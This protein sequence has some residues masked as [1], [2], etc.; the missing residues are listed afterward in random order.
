ML[1]T[2]PDLLS[3]LR[4]AFLGSY[5]PILSLLGCLDGGLEAKRL[6]DKVIDACKPILPIYCVRTTPQT[7]IGDHVVNLREEI[8]K[9]R[10]KYSVAST[11]NEASRE[12]FLD[13]A[14]KGLEQ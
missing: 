12:G 9:N 8:F 11:I 1:L 3:N 4:K 13:H 7:R 6:A 5:S 10:V 2:Q 14:I